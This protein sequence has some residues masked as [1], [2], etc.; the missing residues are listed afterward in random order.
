MEGWGLSEMVAV[1][2]F[3]PGPSYIPG[4]IPLHTAPARLHMSLKDAH[5]TIMAP[6]N[7]Q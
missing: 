5:S 6:K 1:S 3:H 7:T 2:S 4:V